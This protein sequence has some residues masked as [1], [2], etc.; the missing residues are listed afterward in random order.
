MSVDELQLNGVSGIS[1]DSCRCTSGLQTAWFVIVIGFFQ[2]RY[3]AL[4]RPNS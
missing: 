4:T 3:A 2:T 1:G